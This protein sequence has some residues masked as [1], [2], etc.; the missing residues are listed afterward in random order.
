MKLS[1]LATKKE[2]KGALDDFKVE[3]FIKMYTKE[4]HINF[5]GSLTK[6]LDQRFVDLEEKMV[7]KEDHA[8]FMEIFDEA[9]KELRDMREERL[10]TGRQVL[11][12]DDI[13]F[14]HEKRIGVLEKRSI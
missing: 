14:N 11:R 5:V 4:D 3:I 9:M 1:D 2:L 10:L 6:M 13:V 7:S 8:K 12:I